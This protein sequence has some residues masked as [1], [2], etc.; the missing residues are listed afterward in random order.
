MPQER[1]GSG[2]NAPYAPGPRGRLA[3]AHDPDGSGDD[4]P[5]SP[6]AAMR[7]TPKRGAEEAG[8]ADTSGAKRQ[9][10]GPEADDA[11]LFDYDEVLGDLT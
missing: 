6:G 7:T 5:M 8:V 1:P 11:Y 9:V 10:P 2:L 4:E 3:C